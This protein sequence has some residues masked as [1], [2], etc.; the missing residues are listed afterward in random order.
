MIWYRMPIRLTVLTH[1]HK[2]L[3]PEEQQLYDDVKLYVKS[4]GY[5]VEK[6][7]VYNNVINKG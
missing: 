6:D 5:N 7:S 1:P 3:T 2:E 4:L